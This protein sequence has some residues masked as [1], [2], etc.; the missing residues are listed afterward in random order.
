MFIL[1]NTIENAY[2]LSFLFVF[3]LKSV[4]FNDTDLYYLVIADEN[5]LQVQRDE[6]QINIAFAVD[7]FDFFS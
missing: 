5:G 3:N 1:Y 4:K 2:Y 6:F 7:A